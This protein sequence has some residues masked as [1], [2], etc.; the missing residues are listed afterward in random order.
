MTVLPIYGVG[1]CR[2]PAMNTLMVG[3]SGVI[4][5]EVSLGCMRIGGM[6]PTALDQ[7]VSTSLELGINF[8]DHADIYGGG[9]C[10]EVFAGAVKRLGIS[11][12]Q[13]ILQSK[14]GI[15]KGFFD[16]SKAHILS[17]V[18][19]I[20]SRLSTDYLDFLLLHRPDTLIEPDEVAEAFNT[21][22]ASGKVRH[23]GVSNPLRKAIKQQ[24]Q[25][26]YLRQA[27]QAEAVKGIGWHRLAWAAVLCGQA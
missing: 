3:T 14:C 2:I 6:E 9:R 22:Q 23:F 24:H 1:E 15:R 7:L 5:S 4:A 11:R 25:Q 17:S 18:D 19:G 27:Q 10:E 16:F 21:L 8:F 12:D 20:L 13:M 26:M